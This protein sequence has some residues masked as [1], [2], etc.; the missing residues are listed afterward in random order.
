MN[1]KI[2]LNKASENWV[3]D[4]FREEWYQGNRD[5]S[6]RFLQRSNIIWLIA[7][8]VWKKI[9]KKQ[10][11]AKRVIC[12]IH[13]IDMEKF[14]LKSK[15]DF[16][17]RDKYID[18]YHAISKKTE[19]QLKELTSKTIK[20]F[21]FWIN[22]KIW[23]E[24]KNKQELRKKYK[25]S[26]KHFLIGS[27]QRDTEG[28]DLISPKLSKG[29]DQFIEI[30]KHY[31][32]LNKNVHV[33]LSGKRREYLKKQLDLLGVGY[34]YYEM[35]KFNELNE[36][37]NCL[38]LYIVS[39]RVE[40]GPQAILECGIARVPIISTSVGIAPEILSAD[41]IFEMKNF[42]EAKPNINVAY[43]NSKKYLLPKGFK[44]FREIFLYE[45]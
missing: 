16:D 22:D 14:D 28:K 5:I 23:F 45:N 34:S 40:G 29:P 19:Q 1:N 6:T 27:F 4:R 30:V 24:I 39:S 41:S 7:P 43:E 15:K 37:Y 12:T 25:F 35:M 21:P 31:K 20:T 18:V 44:K 32:Y 9:S 10:L 17:E 26:E 3:V 42:K 11:D 13:H 36:L 8:W 38:D 2:Y 33:V